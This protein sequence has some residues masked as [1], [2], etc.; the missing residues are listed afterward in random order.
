MAI[1]N[2]LAVALRTIGAIHGVEILNKKVVTR[3]GIENV[4]PTYGASCIYF[5][6]PLFM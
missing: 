3:I 5:M 1:E 4:A 6:S 2:A